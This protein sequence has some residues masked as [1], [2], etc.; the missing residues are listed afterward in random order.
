VDLLG[1]RPAQP[2]LAPR[3]SLSE[4]PIGITSFEHPF[5]PPNDPRGGANDSGVVMEDADFRVTGRL[6]YELDDTT[7]CNLPSLAPGRTRVDDITGGCDKAIFV[8]CTYSRRGQLG[9]DVVVLFPP[10]TVL[11]MRVSGPRPIG[12]RFRHGDIRRTGCFQT[13]LELTA[14]IWIEPPGHNALRVGVH[15][16]SEFV[17]PFPLLHT[18]GA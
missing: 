15:R 9:L 11:P 8:A 6:R 14:S 2:G 1:I 16:R 12:N 3:N 10:S 4:Q 18:R 17:R 7:T 13:Q 5:D